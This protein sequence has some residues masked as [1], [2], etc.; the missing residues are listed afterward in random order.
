VYAATFSLILFPTV[1]API[2]ERERQ[3][4]R[5]DYQRYCRV[6][7]LGSKALRACMSHS[8]RKLSNLCV[9]ALVDAGELTRVQANKLRKKAGHAQRSRHK[10][11][12]RRAHKKQ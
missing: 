12:H 7:A 2:T 6:Y 5:E 3:D 1:A 11:P 9:G 4:C 10:R 8:I